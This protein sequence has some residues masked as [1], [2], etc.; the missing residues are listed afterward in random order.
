MTLWSWEKKTVKQ[1][2]GIRG[3]AEENHLS[4]VFFPILIEFF[5][6]IKDQ[7]QRHE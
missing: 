7:Q 6:F 2:T 4:E 5:Y 3:F 1:Q